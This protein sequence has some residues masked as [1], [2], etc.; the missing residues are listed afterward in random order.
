[1]FTYKVTGEGVK[2]LQISEVTS[3]AP[4]KEKRAIPLE[5]L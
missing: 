3:D 1:M 2:P 5:A 4:K